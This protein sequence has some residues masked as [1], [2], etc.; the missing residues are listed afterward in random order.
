MCKQNHSD[1]NIALNNLASLNNEEEVVEEN[2]P[3]VV[4]A[5]PR[6]IFIDYIKS[7]NT[8]TEEE[9]FITP[10]VAIQIIDFVNLLYHRTA[11]TTET[12]NALVHKWYKVP[13]TIEKVTPFNQRTKSI[14]DI[15][16]H[17]EIDCNLANLLTA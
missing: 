2:N 13:V 14:Q 11:V 15:I 6:G 12:A 7:L 17:L 1:E 5:V 3:I 8:R 9:A 16:N 4:R 10:N